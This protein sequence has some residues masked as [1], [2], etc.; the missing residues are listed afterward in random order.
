M[1]SFTIGFDEAGYDERAWARQVVERYRTTHVERTVAAAEVG[2]IQ[3]LL[4]RHYDEP[5]GD[6]SSLPTYVLCREAR[7]AITVALSGDGADELFAGYRRYQRLA[8]RAAMAG[9]LPRPLARGLEAASG[10]LWHEVHP[11]R[12]M[13]KQYGLAPPALL[14]DMLSIVAPE[15]LLRRLACAAYASTLDEH[16]PQR[17]V[18]SVLDDTPPDMSLIDAMRQVD[19]ALTLPGDMLVKVDRA[20]MAVALEVRPL[21]LHRDVM[22]IAAALPGAALADPGQAKVALKDAVRPWLPDALLDRP[23][24]GFALPLPRWLGSDATART[25]KLAFDA[26][27][28]LAEWLDVAALNR[29]AEDH[30]RGDGD[31]TQLLYSCSVLER[32]LTHW[33][34]A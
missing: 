11:R 26:G 14:A 30:R 18:A 9:V 16:T 29:L 34:H 3:D 32:W 8:R 28:P 12:R 7:S 17:L 25:A 13:L 21:F 10:A 19:F 5:F 1:R 27:G 20:S 22:E 4:D 31:Y 23:K 15:S 33:T 2:A 6:Y 24:Q